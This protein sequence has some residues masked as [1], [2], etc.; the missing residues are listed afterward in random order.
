MLNEIL[1]GISI[2]LL[3]VLIM[4]T[5]NNNNNKKKHIRE[6]RHRKKLDNLG[7]YI[8]FPNTPSPRIIVPHRP[9]IHD[10]EVEILQVERPKRRKYRQEIVR[11]LFL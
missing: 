7:Y 8:G 2:V 3:I 9:N 6:I 4:L 5:F 11:P 10:T 1:S